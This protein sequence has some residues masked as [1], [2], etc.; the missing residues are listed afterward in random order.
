MKTHLEHGATLA[1]YV[2]A[3][4]QPQA[5]IQLS[6]DE[7]ASIASTSAQAAYRETLPLLRWALKHVRIP[8]GLD[9]EEFAR[10]YNKMQQFL[11]RAGS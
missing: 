11:D 9:A 5:K 7:L 2:F 4:L 3:T 10:Q 1:R 8:D 6:Q